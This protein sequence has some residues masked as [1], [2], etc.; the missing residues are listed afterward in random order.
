MKHKKIS[1]KAHSV[2]SVLAAVALVISIFSI[3]FYTEGNNSIVKNDENEIT[4][5]AVGLEEVTGFATASAPPAPSST[6]TPP[7]PTSPAQPPPPPPEPSKVPTGKVT[8][9]NDNNYYFKE[10]D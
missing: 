3:G 10:R 1:K 4:G 7:K 8:L 6:V 2:G 5:N 9:A